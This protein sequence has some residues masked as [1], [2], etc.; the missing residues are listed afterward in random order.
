MV[1]KLLRWVKDGARKQFLA[2]SSCCTALSC[3]HLFYKDYT[4]TWLHE[5]AG[6]PSIS[7]IVVYT[8]SVVSGNERYRSVGREC[9]WRFKQ[10]ASRLFFCVSVAAAFAPLLAIF[11]GERG[12]GRA[13]HSSSRRGSRVPA[14]CRS[15]DGGASQFPRALDTPAGGIRGGVLLSVPL[16]LALSVSAQYM[17]S[18]PLGCNVHSMIQPLRH[19]RCLSRFPA[20]KSR[21]PTF[22]CCMSTFCVVNLCPQGSRAIPEHN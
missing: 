13:S 3:L 16:W 9:C 4:S 20:V 18:T 6:I 12:R 17:G 19:A 15:L 22:G 10:F 11:A 2:F 14:A 1:P 8:C 7:R 21:H 5:D